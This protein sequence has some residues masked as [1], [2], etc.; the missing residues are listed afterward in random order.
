MHLSRKQNCSSLR[1][2]W[3]IACRRCSNYIFILDLIPRFNISHK[4]NYKTG[5]EF[6]DLVRLIL[7]IWRHILE[8]WQHIS[9][10]ALRTV[11]SSAK[12]SGVTDEDMWA[13]LAGRRVRGTGSS[14]VPGGTHA[15]R[16]D[17][18][19]GLTERSLR[20]LRRVAYFTWGSWPEFT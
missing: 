12:V 11:L 10:T 3:S 17:R 13:G 15:T 20:E 4:D 5:R 18:I 16:P 14:H 1:C 19:V 8:I 7:E 6:W 9:C 2:S